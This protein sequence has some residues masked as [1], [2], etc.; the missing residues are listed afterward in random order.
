[1]PA[2]QLEPPTVARP[3]TPEPAA[4]PSRDE[5][6]PPLEVIELRY[7]VQVLRH[8]QGNKDRAAQLLGIDRRT[9]YRW[10]TRFDL[11]AVVD[12]KANAPFMIE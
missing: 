1:V 12:G 9:L 7:I 5:D 10:R 11:D 8:V 6:F 4:P 2:T 3:R